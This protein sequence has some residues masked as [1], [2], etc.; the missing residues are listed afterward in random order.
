QKNFVKDARRPIKPRQVPETNPVQ[1]SAESIKRGEQIFLQ[2]CTGCHGKKA[3]GKG[4]NSLDIQPRPRN[5][6][7]AAFMSS[8]SD[9]RL[10]ES[11]MYGVQGTAMPPWADY[12]LTQ[13]DIGD[14][15]NYLRSFNQAKK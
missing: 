8:I 7:N 4:P 1:S 6:R 2:R 13:K 11:L 15:V 10:F 3:D 9:R 14:L 12:G 5:L